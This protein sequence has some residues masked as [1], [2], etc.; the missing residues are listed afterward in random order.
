MLEQDRFHNT[1]RISRREFNKRT[2][3]FLGGLVAAGCQPETTRQSPQETFFFPTAVPRE[4]SPEQERLERHAE[5]H[6]PTVE[7]KEVPAKPYLS[8]PFRKSDLNEGYQI[9]E[10]WIYSKDEQAIHGLSEHMGV[11]LAVPYG[12][13]VVSPV[14][15]YVMSSYHTF[16][17]DNGSRY[18]K[19][20]AVRLGLGYFV[21]IYDPSVNRFIQ[22]AHLSEI[23]DSIPFSPADEQPGVDLNYNPTNHDLLIGQ[24]ENH[25]AY[26]EV[27]KGQPLGK[28]G[29]SG[30]AWGLAYEDEYRINAEG[31]PIY[32]NPPIRSWDEPHVH[33]EEFWRDQVTGQKTARR[34]PFGIYSTAEDYSSSSRKGIQGKDPLFLMQSNG[35]P[36]FAG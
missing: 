22:L 14:D 16:W 11:D 35:M 20:Q 23:D 26:I 12:T 28:V 7:G 8:L 36:Q 10:G 25:H 2:L 21:Q 17:V 3:V 9:T 15:G 29:F 13:P 34:D 33:L 31:R 30:L 18:Y 27:A 32:P 4:V 24:M 5:F 6:Y 19:G 1:D